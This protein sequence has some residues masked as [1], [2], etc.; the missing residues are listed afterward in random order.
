MG[1]PAARESLW[2]EL[3]DADLVR[4]VDAAAVLS[5]LVGPPRTYDPFAPEEERAAAIAQWRQGML[6]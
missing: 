5:E 2:I 3:Q 4:R 6:P 1:M